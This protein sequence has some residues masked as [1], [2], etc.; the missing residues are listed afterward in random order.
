MEKGACGGETGVGGQ[1]EVYEDVKQ[2][3]SYLGLMEK[4]QWVGWGRSSNTFKYMAHRSESGS[5][6]L[7]SVCKDPPCTGFDGQR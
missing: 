6:W 4:V 7:T 2:A 1:E 5:N 3:L